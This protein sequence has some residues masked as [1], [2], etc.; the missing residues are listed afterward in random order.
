VYE[1]LFFFPEEC[2]TL[3]GNPGSCNQMVREE[4]VVNT[5]PFDE[6]LPRAE[7]KSFSCLIDCQLDC[8]DEPLLPGKR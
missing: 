8:L 4:E 2:R 6:V 1:G 5:N 3:D 7:G